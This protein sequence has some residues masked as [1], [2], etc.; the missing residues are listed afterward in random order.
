M[1]ITASDIVDRARDILIDT[2][3]VR[4]SDAEMLRW[5]T[6]AERSIVS[7]IPNASQTNVTLALVAGI[8]QTIPAG[9]V[10]LLRAYR[11]LTAGG[12]SG[13]IVHSVEWELLNRQYPTYSN[14]AEVTDVIVYAFDPDD[15]TG[16]YVY[17]PNDGTGSLEINYCTYPPDVTALVDTLV[18]RDIFETALL[19]YVLFRAHAKDN[20]YSGGD[21]VATIYLDNFKA[22][23]EAQAGG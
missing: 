4:W 21:R 15:P 6:D 18:V 17:P 10:T 23:L 16:F 5:V 2:D 13:S 20:D 19:D 3:A 22:F 8:R 12:V 11:N 7:I 9:G 14:D 1:T